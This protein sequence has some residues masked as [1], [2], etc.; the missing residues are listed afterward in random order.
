MSPQDKEVVL[1]ILQVFVEVANSHNWTWFISG[2]SL[3][4]S[5]RHHGITPWD[6]DVDVM[7]NKSHIKELKQVFKKLEPNYTVHDRGNDPILKLFSKRSKLCV[8]K[9]C[10]YKYPYVD[11]CSFTEDKDRLWDTHPYFASMKFKKSYIFP[12]HL[13]PFEGMM[14]YAPK[15]SLHWIQVNY[16]LSNIC[17]TWMY[18]HNHETKSHKV[19]KVKCELLRNRYPFVFR[20]WVNGTM[21]ETLKIGN[22]T[23]GVHLISGELEWTVTKPYSTVPIGGKLL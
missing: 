13:R 12:L 4:G 8:L 22:K 10:R 3:I 9:S 23:L 15:V 2:G 17:Q 16:G 11:V 7:V 1:D 21:E 5:V 18:F 19:V 14:V 20:R 6:D